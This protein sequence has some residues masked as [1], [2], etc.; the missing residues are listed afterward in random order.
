MS[1][2]LL[3]T[4]FVLVVLGSS[5]VRAADVDPATLYDLKFEATPKVALNSEGKVVAKIT[6]RKGAEIH[7]EA[8]ATM[9]L[10]GSPQLAF[11]KRYASK[12]DLKMSGTSASFELPF[13]GQAPGKFEVTADLHFVICTE[14]ACT[15]Q[16]R[17]ATLPVTVTEKP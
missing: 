3:L 12:P 9:Y 11:P 4:P 13:R 10:R 14:K 1:R 2:Y 8:P 16:D 7:K 6:P 15:F 17:H 5:A